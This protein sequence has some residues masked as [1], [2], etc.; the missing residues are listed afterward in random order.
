MVYS[1]KFI[2]IRD[3]VFGYQP[4]YKEILFASVFGK[5]YP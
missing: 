3:K 4:V 5:I 1:I 2:R